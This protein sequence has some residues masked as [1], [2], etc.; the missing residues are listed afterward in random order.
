MLSG[1]QGDGLSYIKDLCQ[2]HIL[3]RYPVWRQININ[4][5]QEGVPITTKATMWAF[6]NACRSRSAEYESQYDAGTLTD[7]A[8]IDYTDITP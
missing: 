1:I 3:K 2:A 5:G 7:P 8:N 4:E 6:I